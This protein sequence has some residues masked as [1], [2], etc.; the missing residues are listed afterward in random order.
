MNLLFSYG[1]LQQESVQRELFGRKLN[2]SADVLHGFKTETIKLEEE[3][4]DAYTEDD[5]FLIALKTGESTDSINGLVLE[6]TEE[7]LLKADAYEP[8]EYTRIQAIT[9]SGKDVWLYAKAPALLS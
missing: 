2:G 9:E 7:E 6:L 1:T 5:L 4:F 3:G 8:K